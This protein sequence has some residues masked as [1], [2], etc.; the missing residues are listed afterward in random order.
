MWHQN[1]NIYTITLAEI[2]YGKLVIWKPHSRYTSRY[3]DH[4]YLT[5]SLHKSEEN[6]KQKKIY[7]PRK[8]NVI[9]CHYIL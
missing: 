6:N 9:L 7:K 5:E 3:I 4:D 1:V 8:H 2:V